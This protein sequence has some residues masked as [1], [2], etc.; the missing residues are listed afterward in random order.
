MITSIHTLIYSDDANATRTFLR[1]SYGHATPSQTKTGTIE[2]A[3]GSPIAT[4]VAEL[5]VTRTRV[6]AQTSAA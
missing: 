5:V 2:V 6:S 1:D 3:R 4:L